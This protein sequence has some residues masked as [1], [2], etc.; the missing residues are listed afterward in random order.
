MRTEEPSSPLLENEAEARLETALADV[1]RIICFA[2]DWKGDPTSK[3]HI[4]RRFSRIRPVEWIEA[5][6]MR[7]PNL[8]SSA[9]WGRIGRKVA[10]RFKRKPGEFKRKPGEGG[11]S[12]PVRVHTPLTVP[13]PGNPLAHR[14]N[15]GVYRR[16]L[17]PLQDPSRPPLHWVYTPTVA[18]YLDLLTDGPLV[19]HCVDRWWEFSEYDSELMRRYHERL[20]RAS[21][22][23]IASASELLGD[24]LPLN[25]NS[26]LVRHG[27]DWGHF[28]PAALNPSE[29][30][31]PAELR[32][33]RGPIV[34]FWGLIHDW[35]DVEAVADLARALPHVNVILIGS[36]RTDVSALRARPNVRLLGQKP[37][38]SLPDYARWFDVA[39]VPFRL[40]EL[41][42]AVNPIKLRE[43]LSAGVPVVA[44]A[45]P[46][47]TAMAFH[48]LRSYE[49]S[50]GL[51]E[52]VSNILESPLVQEDR[53][54]LAQSMAKE[55]WEFKCA[56]M[57]ELATGRSVGAPA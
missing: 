31:K 46:E 11:R 19:Y 5:S 8:A 53:I 13:A 33:L 14:F 21:S 47:V 10:S 2:N 3:H 20:C 45:L 43:Y 15:L 51:V 17:R 57:A 39:L 23:V 6:G 44:T 40:N 50:D 1:S 55:S 16:L 56:E 7:I 22:V 52:Q 42:R 30:A 41:T 24:C 28:A 9:D 27:V 29:T 38:G 32:D 26:H 54:R 48:G 25:P 12:E 35:V 34:G 37:Y 36:A 18:A 4:M 49:G